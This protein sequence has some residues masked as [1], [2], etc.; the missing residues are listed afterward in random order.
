[1]YSAK[2]T[3]KTAFTIDMYMYVFLLSHYKCKIIIQN[4]WVVYSQRPELL[5]EM[6]V[7]E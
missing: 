6:T 5:P 7:P 1:M 4:N 3:N 2:N